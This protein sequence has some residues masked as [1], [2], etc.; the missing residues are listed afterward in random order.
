M[1]TP[2]VVDVSASW[3]CFEDAIDL[4]ARVRSDDA[5]KIARTLSHQNGL[6]VGDFVW[7]HM[8]RVFL[9]WT[10]LCIDLVACIAVTH[11]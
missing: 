2:K 1:L 6:M 5:I 10:D 7:H 9:Q 11:M 8:G 3:M 4:L